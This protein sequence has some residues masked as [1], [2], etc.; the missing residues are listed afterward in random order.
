MTLV[1]EDQ[2]MILATKGNAEV[3]LVGNIGFYKT[4]GLPPNTAN[5]YFE[6]TDDGQIKILVPDTDPLL[7]AVEI[8]GSAS[9]LS[10]SPA[11]AGVMLHVTGQPNEFSSIYNDGIDNYP[12]YIGRRYNGNVASPTQVLAGETI[13][14]FSGQGYSTGGFAP[15]ADGTITLDAL[16]DFTA[17]NQGA[18]WRFLVNPVGGNVRQEVANVSVANGVSAT[19]FTTAGTITATGNVTGGN[20]VTA[21]LVSARNYNGQARNAGTLDAAGTLTIDFATD[22]M[23][24]VNLTTTAT[25]AF[26][27]ITAGKT[28]SVLVKNT[29]GQ[30]RAVTLGVAAENT[31]GGNPAPNVNNNRTGVLI[32]RTFGTDVGNVFCEFN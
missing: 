22:H 6:A 32:Y 19:K 15:P 23:V 30:N 27:N 31:S 7:G 20:I 10:I 3:Q 17:T 2:D 29:T 5:R 25:I 1:N 16:E 9:G 21:A 14:R 11:L 24:L 28:V 13:V 12:N 4:N 18:I 8:I 26:A